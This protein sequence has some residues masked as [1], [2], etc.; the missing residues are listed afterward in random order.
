MLGQKAAYVRV[1]GFEPEQHRQMILQYV[2]KH[3]AIT[4]SEAADLCQVGPD[5]ATRIL[6]GLV[7]EGHLVLR[8]MGRGAYYE[9]AD[10]F[11]EENG[12]FETEA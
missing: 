11:R 2:R 8:G 5:Q 3:N 1:R 10:C 6:K 12:R 9:L 4:R 7:N